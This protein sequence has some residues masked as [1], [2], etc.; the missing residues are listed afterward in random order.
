MR[1]V[2]SI[3]W[4]WTMW[5]DGWMEDDG[6]RRVPRGVGVTVE[7]TA[8]A[9]I[10]GEMQRTLIRLDICRREDGGGGGVS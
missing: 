4:R 7:T 8:L 3:G 9:F 10:G 6:G 5:M 1:V 2:R